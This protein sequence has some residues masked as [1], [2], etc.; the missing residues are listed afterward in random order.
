[1]GPGLRLQSKRTGTSEIAWYQ[2]AIR[3]RPMA[4]SSPTAA[5]SPASVLA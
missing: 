3:S 2:L 4:P 1:L 5:L